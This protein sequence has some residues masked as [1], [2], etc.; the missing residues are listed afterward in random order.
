MI[1]ISDE[2]RAKIQRGKAITHAKLVIDDYVFG[3]DN[4][5]E[6]APPKDNGSI[7]KLEFEYNLS[8]DDFALGAGTS[9]MCEV[10][11]Y[12][13]QNL[14]F[15]GKYLKAYIGYELNETFVINGRAFPKIE[16]VPMGTFFVHDMIK[17]GPLV[18]ITGYD[19]MYNLSNIIYVPS[20]S[21]GSHPK[22]Y[23]VFMD[24]FKFASIPYNAESFSKMMNYTVDMSLIYGTEK[25][26]NTTGYTVREVLMY[27]AGRAGGCIIV[28]RYDEV[29]F[30]EYSFANIN[31]TVGDFSVE[32]E[33]L[34]TDND[35]ADF[36]VMGDG[37]HGMKYIECAYSHDVIRYENS[38]TKYKNGFVLDSPIVTIEED[39]KSVLDHI[40]SIYRHNGGIFYMTPCYFKLMNGDVSIELADIISYAKNKNFAAGTQAYIPI[41]HIKIKYTGKPDIQ[42]ESYSKTAAEHI[43]RVGPVHRSFTAF[44]RVSNNNYQYLDEAFKTVSNQIMGADGGYIVVDK[45]ED[46]TWRQMRV[47]DKID[48]PGSMIVLN[49]N[50]IGFSNDGSGNIT[51][52][53]ITIDGKI[54]ANGMT[55][56]VL[57]AAQGEI[58]GWTIGPNNLSCNAVYDGK[59]YQASLQKYFGNFDT[60]AAFAVTVT[61]NNTGERSWPLVMRYNGQFIANNAQIKGDVTADSGKIGAWTI[62]DGYLQ[63]T[64]S[65]R[66]VRIKAISGNEDNIFEVYNTVSGTTN[67]SIDG[68]GKLTVG[69]NAVFKS[70]ATF[71]HAYFNDGINLGKLSAGSLYVNSNGLVYSSSSSKRYKENVTDELPAELNPKALYDLPVVAFNYKDEFA[72]KSLVDGTQ[73]GLI[74]EDVAE[75]FPNA[76]IYNKEGEVENWQER[77]MIPAMLKLI[78]EQKQEIDSLKAQLEGQNERLTA[79]EE[80]L[81][82]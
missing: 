1:P 56:G 53:A 2:L 12:G 66:R 71:E 35:V 67:F 45:N 52:A 60:N 13:A 42:I 21:L 27:L 59:T 61:D 31:E 40:N 51:S 30:V 11:L 74:A 81:N 10:I 82:K 24:I 54:V 8:E 46:G 68:N 72:D 34:I 6:T 23:N 44:K 65:S 33:Y 28:N 37:P 63:S 4:K 50:G 14:N 49:K 32:A 62:A 77:I 80:L 29:Q 47:L 76:A 48:K 36:E 39:A 5:N 15:E 70:D 69:V 19:R 75:I 26:G 3:Y 41:M 38:T 58:G 73:I 22:A 55:G 7:C 79:I 64:N 20:S 18:S 78:Q 57:Q 16:W 43:K 9:Q 25:D 17:K